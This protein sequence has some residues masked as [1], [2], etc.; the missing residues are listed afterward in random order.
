VEVRHISRSSSATRQPKVD[1]GAKSVEP[2]LIS[3]GF[4]VHSGRLVTESN[5]NQSLNQL[6]W[7]CLAESPCHQSPQRRQ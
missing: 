5:L 2:N 4:P 3:K 1:T 6:T 7:T